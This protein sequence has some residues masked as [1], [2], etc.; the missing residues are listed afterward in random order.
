LPRWMM[1]CGYP[2][3]VSRGRRAMKRS[4]GGNLIGI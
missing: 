4:C 1:W 2:G 3:T